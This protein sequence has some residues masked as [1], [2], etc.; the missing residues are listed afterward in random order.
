MAISPLLPYSQTNPSSGTSPVSPPLS[1]ER[2]SGFGSTS[3]FQTSSSTLGSFFDRITS[4]VS[5]LWSGFGNA[6]RGIGL[7]LYEGVG[8][9]GS[10]FGEIFSGNFSSGLLSIGKGLISS[11]VQTPLDALLMGGGSAIG[12]FQT[13]FGIEPVGRKLVGSEISGL[14]QVYGDS[15]DFDSVTI[16]E[17]SIG[18][19]GL[20]G[21]PFTLGNTIYVPNDG[22]RSSLNLLVHEMAHVWQNQNG[23]SDYLTEALWA[24]HFG[25]GYNFEKGIASGRSWSE[26]NPEQQAELLQT[27]HAYGFFEN[28]N[29]PFIY[30]GNDLSAYIQNVV[31][32][33]L[34]GLGA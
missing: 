2:S 26:L 12:A 4:S 13:L 10:G 11:I 3:E 6:I 16:K 17:G 18:L 24:Q 23:G 14:S 25:D 31:L 5:G 1:Y 32:Q 15:L 7:D 27:A 28:P 9:I 19:F 29:E 20:P 8:R 21:R 22:S 30:N 34:T 33:V